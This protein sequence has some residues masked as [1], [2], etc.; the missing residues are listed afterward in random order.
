M[1]TLM[2][3]RYLGQQHGCKVDPS[4]VIH[5]AGFLVSAR[6]WEAIRVF[7]HVTLTAICS[8]FVRHPCRPI[9]SDSRPYG[10]SCKLCPAIKDLQRLA[11]VVESQMCRIDGNVLAFQRRWRT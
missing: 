3:T 5:F 1:T 4:R 8:T 7:G 2:P 10:I 6:G 9:L 11:L